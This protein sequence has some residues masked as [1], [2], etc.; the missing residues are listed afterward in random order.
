MSISLVIRKGLILVKR[1]NSDT[2]VYDLKPKQ[3]QT[4]SNALQFNVELEDTTFEQFFMLVAK[5]AAFMEKVFE[6]GMLGHPIRMYIDECLKEPG[7]KSGLEVKHVEV[8][9][10]GELFEGE[11]QLWPHFSGHGIWTQEPYEEGGIAI[12]FTPINEYKALML[13]L[14]SSFVIAALDDDKIRLPVTK[15]FTVYD[16]IHAILDEITWAGDISKGRPSG[17]C[18]FYGEDEEPPKTEVAA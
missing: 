4:L 3:E 13:K 6:A 14:D 9:W 1:W 7:P 17:D 12:E 8:S 2:R 18:P 10:G 15:K 11:L 5:E 16:V